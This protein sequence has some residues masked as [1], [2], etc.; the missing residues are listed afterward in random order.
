MEVLHSVY[1]G[2]GGILFRELRDKRSLAYSVSAG[3]SHSWK[4]GSFVV[5][6]GSAPEKSAEAY[7]GIL[8]ILQDTRERPLDPGVVEGA[9][10][11]VIGR[12]LMERLTMGR[13]AS[14]ALS[15]AL[16][17]RPLDYN[18]A[19]LEIIRK[20]TPEDG[21]RAAKTYLARGRAAVAAIGDEAFIRHI[22]ELAPQAGEA[23][24]YAAGAGG[25]KAP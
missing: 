15:L 12:N 5:Y 8:R 16:T 3:Y 19:F 17:E 20:G 23:G 7:Y 25:G 22:K 11:R 9:K 2:M 4:I 24:A 13:L 14:E 6:I 1:S 18:D 10:N 21:H